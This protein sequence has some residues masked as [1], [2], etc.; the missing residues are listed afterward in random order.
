VTAQAFELSKAKIADVAAAAANNRPLAAT[1]LK[2][3]NVSGLG[4]RTESSEVPAMT[5]DA[6]SA[7]HEA[8]DEIRVIAH[9]TAVSGSYQVKH[10]P[11]PGTTVVM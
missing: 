9:G 1:A 6:L 4:D 8:L 10:Q 7:P 2:E 11:Q 5:V 3:P